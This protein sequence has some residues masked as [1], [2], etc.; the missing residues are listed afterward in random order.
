MISFPDINPT[1]FSIFGI[2]IQWYGIAYATGLL[3]GLF[4]SKKL[5]N[6]KNGL[7]KKAF[8][9]LIFWIALGTIIGGRLGYVIFY[10]LNF[11]FQN[12]LEIFKI[13]QGGMSFHGALIGIILTT[14]AFSIKKNISIFQLSDLLSITAPVGIFLGRISNFLN[15]ELIGKPTEFFFSV[16]YPNEA[17]YRHISQIYEA[18]FEGLI[19]FI[20]LN[21]IF[22]KKFLKIPGLISAL[23]LIFYSIFRFFIEFTREPDEHIG[24]LIF[25]LSMGQIISAIVLLI[26]VFLWQFK[27][28]V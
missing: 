18:I 11:Y 10:N 17:I 7:Q 2:D 14:I 28:N 6:N 3:L 27:K 4:Y 22:K 9:D 24:L 26:G 1:A 20:L 19:L 13:W 12:P 16:R 25:N 5:I 21:F 23:F 15:K 8:D